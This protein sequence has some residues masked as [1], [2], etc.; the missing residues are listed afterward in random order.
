MKLLKPSCSSGGSTEEGKRRKTLEED[1]KLGKLDDLADSLLQALVWLKWR[2]NR[3]ILASGDV[4]SLLGLSSVVADST[5]TRGSRS[6]SRRKRNPSERHNQALV[7]PRAP[8][9]RALG[10]A[11]TY[12][13]AIY[14]RYV[15]DAH[16]RGY[17]LF[18]HATAIDDFGSCQVCPICATKDAMKR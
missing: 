18:K 16:H 2:S 17:P 6:P 1:E 12:L 4:A 10:L 5:E 8:W 3:E 11:S 13:D 7:V 9:L 15:Y 14:V